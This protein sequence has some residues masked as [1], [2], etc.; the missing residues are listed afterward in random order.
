M[1]RSTGSVSQMEASLS[2]LSREGRRCFNVRGAKM[3]ATCADTRSGHSCWRSDQHASPGGLSVLLTN[4][5]KVLLIEPSPLSPPLVSVWTSRVSSVSMSP[6]QRHTSRLQEV[7]GLT[8]RE[9]HRDTAQPSH[10]FKVQ[11]DFEDS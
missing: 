8:F 3:A 6:T 4:H 2:S 11:E 1:N 9:R 7:A 10:G 5:H